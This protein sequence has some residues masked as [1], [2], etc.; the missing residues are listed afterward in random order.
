MKLIYDSQKDHHQIETLIHHWLT[1]RRGEV[2]SGMIARQLFARIYG[3]DID[4]HEY[5]YVLDAM[6]RRDECTHCGFNKNGDTEY[7][8]R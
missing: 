3:I 5:A 2:M 6:S 8:I 4:H 7:L 1:S